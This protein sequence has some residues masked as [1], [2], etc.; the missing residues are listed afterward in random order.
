MINFP[1][2]SSGDDD[3]L[4]PTLHTLFSVKHDPALVPLKYFSPDRLTDSEQTQ[5]D[6]PAAT[7]KDEL[8]QWI[9]D[10]A[11]DGDRDAALWILLVAVARVS[12]LLLI[13]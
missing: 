13:I 7:I 4:V 1:S 9:A 6:P 8:V 2:L 3:S 12:V 5:A 10:A 11:L